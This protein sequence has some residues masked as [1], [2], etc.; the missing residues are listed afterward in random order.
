MASLV[1]FTFSFMIL[2]C[3]GVF[4]CAFC[5]GGEG[6]TVEVFFF[7]FGNLGMCDVRG[8]T[9]TRDVRTH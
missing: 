5:F 8:L 6:F 1:R 7:N 4:V 3:V 2:S 9:A